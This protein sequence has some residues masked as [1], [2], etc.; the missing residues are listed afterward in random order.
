M[1]WEI[2]V[3]EAFGARMDGRAVTWVRTLVGADCVLRGYEAWNILARVLAPEH[4]RLPYVSWASAPSPEM[5]PAYI[6]IWLVAAAAFSCGWRPLLSG[7]VLS[8]VMAYTLL[9]DQQTYSNHL[10]LLLLVVSLVT[11]AEGGREPSEPGTTTVLAWPVTLLKIQV[12]IVYFFGA[13]SK[14]NALF[15]SGTI[16]YLNLR[17]PLKAVAGGFLPALMVVSALSVLLE[18]WL[19]A[20]LWSPRWRSRA[21]SIGLAFHVGIVLSLSATESTQLLVFTVMMSTLYVLFFSH[22]PRRVT[23]YYDDA[24]KVCHT[25]I[26]WCLAHQVQPVITAV[27]STDRARCSHGT[28]GFDVRQS[29]VV[30]DEQTGDR[31]VGTRAFAALILALPA[32]YQPLR[33]AALPGFSLV[34]DAACRLFAQ[35]GLPR[36]TAAR[37]GDTHARDA[38]GPRVLLRHRVRRADH[39]IGRAGRSSSDRY[40][41]G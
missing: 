21:V 7:A 5:L 22:T 15:L 12:S 17:P 23:V 24:C 8:V 18:L 4:L 31:A 35:A 34:S 13:V 1:R 39:W 6:A 26:A 37:R 32:V 29:V 20:A 40:L 9:I 16:I 38:G 14:I 30:V 25:V 11:V 3:A 36:Y 33:L 2:T 27:G 28:S 41:V 10:Y 19:A